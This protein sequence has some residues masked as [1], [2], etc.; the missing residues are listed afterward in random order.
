MGLYLRH[1]QLEIKMNR[2]HSNYTGRIPRDLT[3]AFG[4]YAS[5]EFTDE[6]PMP[7]A[8]KI[9]LAVSLIALVAVAV[10]AIVGWLPA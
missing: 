3:S 5:S 7:K 6:T 1:Q 9:V 8:D 10:M 2:T 4:P